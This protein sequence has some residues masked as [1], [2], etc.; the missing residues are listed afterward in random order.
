MLISPLCECLPQRSAASPMPDEGIETLFGAF[1]ENLRS[2]ES[3]HGCTLR[4]SG[5]DIVVGGSG[6]RSGRVRT[7]ARATGG[8]LREGYRFARG[9]VKTA[10]QSVA[11]DPQRRTSGLLPQR[12][13]PRRGPPAGHAEDASRSG[14]ISKPSTS[15]TSCLAWARRHRQD[16]PGD[17]AGR[18]VSAREAREPHRPRAPGGRGGREARVPPGDLQEKVNPYLRPLYDA[19]YDMLEPNAS[20]GCSSAARSKWR[21][22]RSCAAAR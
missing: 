20:S 13:Q 22:S 15:T 16:L 19:L 5:H 2:L 11:Q 3:A 18:V 4:T 10:A 6:R 1:D 17:G 8:L 21:R 14:G 12:R 7:H 9:D